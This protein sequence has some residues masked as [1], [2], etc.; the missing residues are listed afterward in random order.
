[1]PHGC[2]LAGTPVAHDSW[3]LSLA[4]AAKKLTTARTP[5]S[6]KRLSLVARE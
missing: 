3:R 5:S 2:G 4:R 6:W 1:M